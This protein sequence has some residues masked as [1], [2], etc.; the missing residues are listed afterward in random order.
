MVPTLIVQNGLILWEGII[1]SCPGIGLFH[2]TTGQLYAE[3]QIIISKI[4]LSLGIM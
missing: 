1:T 3:L 2:T 4:R